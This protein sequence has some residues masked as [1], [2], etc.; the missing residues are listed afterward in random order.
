M[1]FSYILTLSDNGIVVHNLVHL[2]HLQLH[3]LLLIFGEDPAQ[4]MHL[5]PHH[6]LLMVPH[7]ATGLSGS[8]KLDVWEL[9]FGVGLVNRPLLLPYLL[10]PGVG[11]LRALWLVVIVTQQLQLAGWLAGW[12]GNS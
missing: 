7:G 3:I 8:N 5:L 10:L 1:A 4:L 9:V 11:P 12:L 6:L 2:L